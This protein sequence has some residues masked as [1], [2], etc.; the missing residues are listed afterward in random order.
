MTYRDLESKY[1]RLKTFAKGKL[2]E[3]R[4][5]FETMSPE[6]QK[7]SKNLIHSLLYQAKDKSNAY[8][9]SEE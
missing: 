3:I 4:T 8:A 7:N 5:D 1:Q 9:Y 6:Q 2:G